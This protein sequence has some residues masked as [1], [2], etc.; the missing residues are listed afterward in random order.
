MNLLLK[1]LIGVSLFLLAATSAHAIDLWEVHGGDPCCGIPTGN[2]RYLD[3]T[4]ACIKEGGGAAIAYACNANPR[5][6]R[7]F[8]GGQI[9]DGCVYDTT[10]TCP[11]CG[12]AAFPNGGNTIINPL[13]TFT[14][15]IPATC[16]P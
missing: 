11:D 5:D 15:R 16:P 2:Y 9:P 4:E 14:S 1:L 3:A 8:A 6:V 10:C 7:N 13:R 12:T